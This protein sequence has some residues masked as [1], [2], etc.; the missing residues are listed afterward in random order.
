MTKRVHYNKDIGEY[1]ATAPLPKI[2][3]QEVAK[4]L[5]SDSI[6]DYDRKLIAKSTNEM[7]ATAQLL[8]DL[9][10]VPKVTV[11]GS[12]RTK[13]EHPDYQL[14]VEFSKMIADLGYMII[15]GAGPGIMAAG[16]EGA[17]ADKAI[18][19]G[20]N[21][22]FEEG[23]NEH[24]LKSNYVLTYKYFF[25][26]KLTFVRE[27]DAIVLFPGG[28][29]TMDE[30]FEVL[31]L[32]HT[33]RA[34]P[35]PFVL[36]DHEDSQYWEKWL[37]F[38]KEGLLQE[39]MISEADLYM[40]RRF[41]D[42]S[43]AVDYI[44]N[45]YRRYHSLRYMDERI[46]LRL[47]SPLPSQLEQE[48]I[49]E[50]AEFLGEFGIES[51]AHA[52]PEEENEPDLAKLPR[53]VIKANKQRPMDLYRFVRSLNREVGASSTSQQTKTPLAPR[54]KRVKTHTRQK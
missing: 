50:Y 35:L 51:H 43:E 7:I 23:I 4:K 39:G 20:I 6:S 8:Q 11:F 22:P 42:P 28:F 2:T 38:V 1:D 40:F 45:F 47:N 33:G 16:H 36:M 53:I 48:L 44:H 32:M 12:A 14:C 34:M 21:L 15:T 27:A 24:T 31:T 30:C 37:D 49:E 54:P 10:D 29:G 18:G 25:N 26:R 46:I 17:G 52:L 3:A 19:I 13:P 41:S 5:L 9:R